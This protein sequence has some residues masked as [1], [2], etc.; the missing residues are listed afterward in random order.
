MSHGAHGPPTAQKRA[1]KPRLDNTQRVSTHLSFH[2]GAGLQVP[3]PERRSSASVYPP[4]RAASCWNSNNPL[5]AVR[6]T[7]RREHDR[8][9]LPTQTANHDGAECPSA[10]SG[11]MRFKA[12]CAL[13]SVGQSGPRVSAA[14]EPRAGMWPHLRRVADASSQ[15][16]QWVLCVRAAPVISRSSSP[17]AASR[18]ARTAIYL[19]YSCSC[20]SQ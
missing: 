1:T 2:L 5:G 4:A 11:T 20:V 10:H 7:G 14:A 17:G 15:R 9:L 8:F 13:L 6:G 18:T 3:L 19:F 12:D 16:P